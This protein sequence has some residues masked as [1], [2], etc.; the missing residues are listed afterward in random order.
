MKKFLRYF[1]AVLL[2]L[3][4]LVAV[5]KTE[6]YS[7]NVAK[8]SHTRPYLI[9]VIGENGNLE[10]EFSGTS[11]ALIPLQIAR[12]LGANPDEKDL[13][14]AFPDIGMGIGSKITMHRTPTY[15]LIDGKKKFEIK[16]WAETIGE[17]LA[18][19]KTSLGADDKINFSTDTKLELGMTIVIIR[20]A[21]TTVDEYE[22]ITFQ[23]TKK[24]DATL[25][26]GTKIVEQ[27]G[28]SGQKKL[29]YDVTREDGVEISRK[30]KST[31]VTQQPINE[32][33]R[34]GTKVVV[35]GQGVAS[36]WK[37]SSD[38]IAACN[39]VPKGSKVR[40]VN[41]GNGKS[42]VVTTQGGGLRSDR[43]IDLSDAAFQALGG[44]WS[45][46]L[47]NNVRVEKYYPE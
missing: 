36:I 12:E 47:L 21:H 5:G 17:M 26:K 4:P 13:F 45:V 10:E 6:N 22:Q 34:I 40:V 41:V 25:E 30:L 32:I 3:T 29:T 27:K 18:E 39:L 1:F 35:Y 8:N 28:Q 9:E 19:N 43:V 20:V 14:N 46:G 23:V 16:T 24:N 42:V 2:V 44:S 33:D 31:E 11:Q 15:T 7:L 37:G 38:F